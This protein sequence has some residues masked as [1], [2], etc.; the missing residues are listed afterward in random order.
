MISSVLL[1]ACDLRNSNRKVEISD[2]F[3]ER[4]ITGVIFQ[5]ISVKETGRF[6]GQADKDHYDVLL[7]LKTGE[8]F[9]KTGETG[10]I[11]G[12]RSIVRIPYGDS[13]TVTNKKKEDFCF[14]RIRKD[15]DEK[16]IAEIRNKPEDHAGLYLRAFEDCP[17]YTEDIKSEK[18]VNRMMLAEGMVPRFCMGSVETMGPDEVAEHEHPMLDQVLLGLEDCQCTVHAGDEEALLM[19]NLLLHIPLGSRHGVTVAEG[20]KLTYIW[21]DFFL[22]LEGQKYMEEQH[23]IKDSE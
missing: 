17:V 4:E 7:T 18:T 23:H 21:M 10:H 8:A 6:T 5:F 9:L 22:S 11:L 16:D 15:L 3:S 14:L 2:L 13:Y 12:P 1:P 19:E 20:E